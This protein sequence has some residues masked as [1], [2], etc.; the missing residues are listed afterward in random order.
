[1]RNESIQEIFFLNL[2]NGKYKEAKKEVIS[3][4]DSFHDFLAW[5]CLNFREH[6]DWVDHHT[7]YN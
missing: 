1:M 5:T 2:E 4:I 6:C 7:G 3:E